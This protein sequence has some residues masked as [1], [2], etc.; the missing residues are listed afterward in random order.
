M[1]DVISRI[2]ILDIRVDE[3][4]LDGENVLE[5]ASVAYAP[6]KDS[7]G[8]DYYY[9]GII[10]SFSAYSISS[11]YKA[12]FKIREDYILPPIHKLTEKDIYKYTLSTLAH[13][14]KIINSIFTDGKK[15]PLI[16]EFTFEELAAPIK[17]AL[18][19]GV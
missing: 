2:H 6:N 10:I 5:Q 3:E 7:I 13:L 8:E 1:E 16:Q 4:Y 18:F 9:I 19:K 15:K 17:K 11:D 12:E 14:Q